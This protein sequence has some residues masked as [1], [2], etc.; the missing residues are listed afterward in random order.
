MPEFSLAHRVHPATEGSA[1]HPG[2][3]LLHGRGADENDLLPLAPELDGR[4][5]TVSA[6]APLRFP[7][8]G[9]MWYDLD[10]N[11]VGFPEP[12]TFGSSVDLLRR[13]MDEI[14]DAYPIDGTRL[15]A[16]GFSM[17]AVMAGCL[18]LLEPERIAGAILLSGYLPL[19]SDVPFRLQDAAGH[20]FFQAHGTLDGVIPVSSGRD[21]REY[22]A[23]TPVAL[24]YHEY[25]MG[26]EIS[27]EEL[28]D[29]SAWLTGIL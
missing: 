4:L 6:R 19:G 1:P 29:L 12:D 20:P 7:W 27:Y 10:P 16:G 5:F 9:Y 8:G 3:L 18:A 26:H 15:Y 24:T 2:L 22:L 11:A 25:P 21:T 23:R 28:R 14:L 17:G 13:F